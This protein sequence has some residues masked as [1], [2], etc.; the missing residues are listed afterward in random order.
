MR[1]PTAPAN[2]RFFGKENQ[3]L[4]T[5]EQCASTYP[6]IQA[7]LFSGVNGL[8]HTPVHR[9]PGNCGSTRRCHAPVHSPR[10]TTR[11]KTR[12]AC[13]DSRWL[14]SKSFLASQL[15]NRCFAKLSTTPT[16]PHRL[17]PSDHVGDGPMGH[18]LPTAV[19]LIPGS[20]PAILPSPHG[21]EHLL[22]YATLRRDTPWP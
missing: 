21:C 3:G 22:A 16:T 20:A 18:H 11:L 9:N 2:T 7:L 17:R 10:R 6:A 14:H 4:A 12:P 19:K 5:T 15:S 1:L 8:Q 13:A